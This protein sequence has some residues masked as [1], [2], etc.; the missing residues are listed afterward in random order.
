MAV[1][2]LVHSPTKFRFVRNL[3]MDEAVAVLLREDCRVRVRRRLRSH[4][5]GTEHWRQA[6]TSLG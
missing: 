6:K 5:L 4:N 2:Q 1:E 3:W